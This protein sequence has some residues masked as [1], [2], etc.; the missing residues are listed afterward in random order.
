MSIDHVLLAVP[1]GQVDAELAF[2]LGAFAGLGVV[3][4]TR[5]MPNVVGFGKQQPNIWISDIDEDGN[6]FTTSAEGKVTRVHLALTAASKLRDCQ[7]V[8]DTDHLADRPQ[9]AKKWTTFTPLVARLEARITGR[10]GCEQ[11]IIPITMPLSSS[12]LRDTISR[13][14][15]MA[16]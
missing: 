12:A 2:C 14:S 3:E 16:V 13:W 10:R 7:L 4:I 15:V 11:C 1:T 8:A 5:P 9:L 6:A